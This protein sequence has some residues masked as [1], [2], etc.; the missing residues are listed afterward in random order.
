MY[1]PSCKARQVIALRCCFAYIYMYIY[2]FVPVNLR[3]LNCAIASCSLLART[4]TMN[5]ISTESAVNL[6]WSGTHIFAG[7]TYCSV[8]GLH[9]SCQLS[10][11]GLRDSTHVAQTPYTAL[12]GE[13]R[14][15]LHQGHPPFCLS[16][17]PA[18]LLLSYACPSLYVMNEGYIY[19]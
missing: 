2:I 9:G 19:I 7:I 6:H 17:S 18:R 1:M 14:P 16:L 13:A 4:T 10:I 11:F 5:P 3:H 8:A 15:G 12:S